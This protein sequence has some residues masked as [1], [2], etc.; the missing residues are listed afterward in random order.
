[1]NLPKQS[2]ADAWKFGAVVEY[3]VTFILK[4]GTYTLL[5]GHVNALKAFNR[6]NLHANIK[7][8]KYTHFILK[9][10]TWRN[11]KF[12]NFSNFYLSMR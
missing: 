8:R 12:F 7:K 3:T 6:W 2:S 5:E 11:I 9:V 1:M 10:R 4:S